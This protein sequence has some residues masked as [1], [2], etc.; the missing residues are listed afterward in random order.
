MDLQ[1]FR[2]DVITSASKLCLCWFTCQCA[3]TGD[4]LPDAYYS[5][6]ILT[7]MQLRYLFLFYGI[8]ISFLTDAYQV[9]LKKAR[10]VSPTKNHAVQPMASFIQD[11]RCPTIPYSLDIYTFGLPPASVMIGLLGCTSKVGAQA[12][13]MPEYKKR[14]EQKRAVRDWC[15]LRLVCVLGRRGTKPWED[16]NIQG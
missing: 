8:S 16:E 5:D 4:V 3:F 12:H 9:S 13:H 11:H 10:P 6:P 14:I 15:L 7:C 1:S 2:E